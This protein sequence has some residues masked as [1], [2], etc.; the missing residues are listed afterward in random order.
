M[1]KGYD[2]VEQME[3]ERQEQ[4][5][6]FES[7][8]KP[9]LWLSNQG[10][11]AVVR[12]LE[13]GPDIHNYAIHP[14]RTAQG[15]YREF[16]CLN[17]ADDGTPC[18]ACQAGVDRKVKGVFNVIQRQRPVLRKDKDGRAMKDSNNNYIVDGHQDE[19]V[20]LKV[21]STTLSLIKEKD[22]KYGGMMALDVEIARTGTQY[23]PYN[24]EPADIDQPKTPMSDA[25]Q[26]L[27]QKRHD[28]DEF[29]KPPSFA[30][31]AKLAARGGGG[32]QQ[33]QAQSEQ[34]APPPSPGQAPVEAG[35]PFLG[36]EAPTEPAQTA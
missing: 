35:N 36:E 12:F 17:D 23:S 30:E 34:A 4:Q 10:D 25:D 18:P 1:A 6:R 29:M 14:Y 7:E 31:A 9:Q 28:L 8:N 27:A 20:I 11:R 22:S 15:K 16:T 24:L 19:V 13:Q 3:Q 33:Q 26:V 5:Q 21:P 32:G 2:R